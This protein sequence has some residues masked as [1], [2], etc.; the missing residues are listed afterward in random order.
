MGINKEHLR[1]EIIR[2]ALRHLDPDIPYSYAAEELLMGTC[3]QE[4]HMGEYLVQLNQGPAKGIFQM[5][6]ATE[7]D[8]HCNYLAYRDRLSEKVFYCSHGYGDNPLAGNL[9]YAAVMARVHYYRQPGALPD[10]YNIDQLANYWKLYY[11]TPEG[12]GTEQEFIENYERFV[13]A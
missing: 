9:Y 12:K 4:S 13:N 7:N 3:A 8:I 10:A 6:P 5:E 1:C 2:P 11:N